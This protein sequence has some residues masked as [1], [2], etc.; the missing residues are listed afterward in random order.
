MAPRS[1]LNQEN[2]AAGG[3]DSES[4][5]NDSTTSYAPPRKVIDAQS[6]QEF[7]SLGGGSVPLN[8]RP[9]ITLN[10]RSS[11]RGLART[12]ENFPALGGSSTNGR[13][14]YRPPPPSSNAASHM[15][16]S[17]LLFKTPAAAP[18]KAASNQSKSNA[19]N[20]KTKS[21]Q[22]KTNDF[23]A[24]PGGPILSS[25]R[26]SAPQRTNIE[27][28]LVG[29]PLRLNAA[30]VSTK[31]RA[32]AQPALSGGPISNSQRSYASQRANIESDLVEVP[33][34]LNAAAVSA[35]HRALVQPFEGIS[36]AAA[37][38]S[39]KLKTIQRSEEKA[40]SAAANV[41]VPSIKSKDSFPALG[42]GASSSAAAPQW[43]NATNGGS[44]KQNQIS[45]KLKVAPAPLLPTS[46]KTSNDVGNNGSKKD[47]DAK[48]KKTKL[49]ANDKKKET[50]KST[51]QSNANAN[52]NA[53]NGS[54]NAKKGEKEK[55]TA[56]KS[57][58]SDDNSKKTKQ[59][60]EKNAS[61]RNGNNHRDGAPTRSPDTSSQISTTELNGSSTSNGVINSYSS[62]AHFTMPP[63]GFPAKTNVEK[64]NV[65]APPGFENMPKNNVKNVTTSHTFM[66]PSN[67]LQRNNVS[68]ATNH[69]HFLHFHKLIV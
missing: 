3:M 56:K 44:K 21:A 35:K 19:N 31:H 15:N 43:L 37:T 36:L 10:M 17:T 38:A 51:E 5:T 42:G 63:P 54:A 58:T 8:I 61:E 6:E 2:G 29:V 9:T 27:N 28:D 59:N 52:A 7:P 11:A 40:P 53:T 12:K 46:K 69:G 13:D 22:M 14:S 30:A 16:A 64:A 24:L 1:R 57:A 67:S 68:R 18:S 48:E 41:H 55:T 39:Q 4:M 65:K 62:V 23:P 47:E 32:L 49:K 25:Q 26:S 50:A 34:R 33:L 60:N 20:N 45:K 66:S